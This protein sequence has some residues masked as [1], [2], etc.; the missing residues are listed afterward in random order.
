M[1]H[2]PETKTMITEEHDHAFV[3]NATTIQCIQI[4]F[5]FLIHWRWIADVVV[6]ECVCPEQTERWLIS[7]LG[8]EIQ[9]IVV[10]MID[11]VFETQTKC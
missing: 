11:W 8:G 6:A 3:K 9:R 10:D 4:I 1:S 5:H 2:G 7:V